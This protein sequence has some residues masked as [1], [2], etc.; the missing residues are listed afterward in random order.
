VEALTEPE[1]AVRVEAVR[2]LAEIQGHDAALLLRMK[3]RI[4]DEEP[5]IV[6]EVFDAL[7]KLEGEAALRFVARFL[8][9]QTKDVREEAALAMGASRFPGAVEMLRDACTRTRDPRFREVLF[10][11]L[12]LS[13]QPRA[14]DFLKEILRTGRRADL[15]AVLEALEPHR[16]NADIRRLLEEAEA[17]E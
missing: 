12:C 5:H 11:A 2:G 15:K 6:G 17:R 7:W 13:R 16:E 1:A 14:L 3:A 9:S 8:E 4:G 10:R